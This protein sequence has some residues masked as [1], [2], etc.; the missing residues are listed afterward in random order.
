MIRAVFGSSVVRVMLFPGRGGNDSEV[1]ESLQQLHSG[2]EFALLF[3][4]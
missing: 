2:R 4:G 3:R 1:G